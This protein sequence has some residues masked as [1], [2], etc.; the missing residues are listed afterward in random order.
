MREEIEKIV[1]AA[2][3][4]EAGA[5]EI[6]R[7]EAAYASARG[8]PF[9]WVPDGA[10]LVARIFGNSRVLAGR[11]AENPAWAEKIALSPYS[12]RRKPIEVM[13][14]ELDAALSSAGGDEASFICAIC[15]FKY[16]EMVRVVM[17]DLAEAAPVSELL[18][19]WS[20]VADAILGAA[21]GRSQALMIARSG[22]PTMPSPGGGQ[23]PCRGVVIAL[24]KLGGRELNLSSDVDLMIIY[25]T[26]E[27]GA[28]SPSGARTT[29][30][31]FYVKLASTFTRLVSRVTER[32]F[33]FR[34][35]HELRPEGPQGP[36]ANS[37]DAAE[38]YYEYFGQDWERQA[39]IRAR[40]VAGDLDL[41]AAFVE[42]VRPF[43]FR[44]SM[45]LADLAHMRRMKQ[46]MERQAERSGRS[47]DIKLGRGGIRE[48][49]FLTQALCLLFGGSI[50]SVR[51]G[52]TFEAID[53]LASESIVHPFGARTLSEAYSFLRRLENMLQADGDRQTHTLPEDER[54]LA[55]L[56]RRMG[57]RGEAPS[58]TLDAELSRHRKAVSRLFYALFTADYER[59]ELMDA[60]RD[61]AERAGSEEEEI[62]SL[63]WFRAQESRRVQELDL[64]R[65]MPHRRV[66]ERL[67]IAAEAVLAC[68]LE[69][70][71]RHMRVRFGRPRLDGGPGAGFAIVGLGS[72]G[73]RELDYGSDLDLCFIYEG[74]GRTD[75]D[76][77]IANVEYFTRLAQRIISMIS[78]PGRY[79]RAYSVDSELRPSGRAGTLVATLAS[80]VEYHKGQSQ[81][82]ERRSLMKARAIAGDE[83]FAA[84][85]GHSVEDLAFGLA[86]PPADALREEIVRLRKRAIDERP[87]PRPGAFDLKSGRGGLAELEAVVQMHQM[88][89]ANSSERLHSQ[90]TLDA[91][92]A[93][94]AEGVLPGELC[95][96]LTEQISFLRRVV[97]RVRL[98]AGRSADSFSIDDPGAEAVAERMGAA[99]AVELASWLDDRMR[100]SASVF[101]SQMAPYAIDR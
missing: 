68:A 91:L 58:A 18:A 53:A 13:R 74:G 65:G 51:R 95:E 79:G 26:D 60:I 11:L 55:A 34:V 98:F 49:E 20:D 90:N 66:M 2:A 1:A 100:W 89:S 37:L 43:V 27:G 16:G 29:S 82:W 45:S 10:R 73:S 47:G 85:V 75:G 41:G 5:R 19:E 22:K 96:G 42:A 6:E 63:A 83:E 7:F 21:W 87:R 57:F 59:L 12:S 54:S 50:E 23:A 9:D 56:G 84:R 17:R 25:E 3:E 48:A 4:P 99:G 78:L 69:I 33:G 28:S 30:H 88:L 32:G 31:E 86:P 76:S 94:R 36:L 62:E 61:N 64:T 72:L 14:G 38:R 81:L 93:L 15:D 67:T 24:G 40:P 52:N 97:S 70:A 101:D 8:A 46:A 71:T 44:R 80:F 39:L 77:P 92:D 35:D